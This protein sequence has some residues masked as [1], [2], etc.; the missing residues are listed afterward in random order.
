MPFPNILS[1]ESVR[2]QLYGRPGTVQFDLEWQLKQ[3]GINNVK[4]LAGLKVL[5]IGC[6]IG[7]L[8]NF[9]AG[10]GVDAQGIDEAAPEGERFIRQNV[11]ELYPTEGCIPRET[12]RYDIVY[13]NSLNPL[14]IGFS[15][16][17]HADR[18]KLLLQHGDTAENRRMI[19]QGEENMYNIGTKIISE[20][21]RVIKKGG[22]LVT[23]PYLDEIEECPVDWD[24]YRI[25]K[26]PMKWIQKFRRRTRGRNSVIKEIMATFGYDT[27][28]QAIPEFFLYRLVIHK[29]Q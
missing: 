1:S 14:T 12:E 3:L 17:R 6:G 10:K 11:T 28:E 15:T 7:T 19:D 5:D 26:Q 25:E 29:L 8:V 16:H 27:N 20:G 24:G 2:N 4:K 23:S 22:Q 21:L 9:L 18:K 13:I